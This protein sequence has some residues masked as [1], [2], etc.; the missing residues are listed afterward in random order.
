MRINAAYDA[1][2]ASSSLFLFFIQSRSGCRWDMGDL[3]GID[4]LTRQ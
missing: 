1:A 3:T 2:T 4:Y